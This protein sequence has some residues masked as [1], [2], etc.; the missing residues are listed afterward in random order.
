MTGLIVM[1]MLVQSAD[2]EVVAALAKT[3][4]ADRYAFKVEISH[5]GGDGGQTASVEGRFQKEQPVWMKSGELEA[6]RKGDQM[7]VLRKGE[8]KPE[9]RDT[10]RRRVRGVFNVG[11]LRSLRL[12]HEELAGLEK[13]FT[14]FR[15][16]ESKEG[17]QDVY[18]AD[19]TETAGKAFIAEHSERREEGTLEGT[20]RFWVMPE[21]RISMVEIIARIKKSK[22]KDSGV[23]MWI[24]MSDVGAAKVDVPESAAKVLGEK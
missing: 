7:V 20:G 10:D 16:L 5:Q 1:A 8:W 6:F 2:A 19:L 17:D 4:T 21:G 23:S 9:N 3:R 12:P 15:K 11:A 22:G 24:T 14:G 13:R 18:V